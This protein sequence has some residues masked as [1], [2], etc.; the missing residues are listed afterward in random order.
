[1]TKRARWI[2]AL[3]HMPQ[4]RSH[5]HSAGAL[6]SHT[7]QCGYS[8]IGSRHDKI[9]THVR[10]RW[11]GNEEGVGGAGPIWMKMW[12]NPGRSIPSIFTSMPI[13][14]V[15]VNSSHN[16]DLKYLMLFP[17]SKQLT[18]ITS[19]LHAFSE[20]R[21]SVF[22]GWTS[23]TF[24]PL[25]STRAWQVSRKV[26]YLGLSLW[27]KGLQLVEQLPILLS[28]RH[29]WELSLFTLKRR[30]LISLSGELNLSWLSHLVRVG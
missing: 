26:Q 1:M 30:S 13:Y 25:A 2:I 23:G 8:H 12:S 18:K 28:I 7:S 22:V 16:I 4:A 14:G 9:P 24:I 29:W 3:E 20:P 19:R 27:K 5:L 6:P 15:G 21:Q 10:A 11:W 17:V